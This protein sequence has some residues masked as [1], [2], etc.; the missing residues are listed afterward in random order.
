MLEEFEFLVEAVDGETH[1]VVEAAVYPFNGYATN[2][3][4]DAVG[5]GFVK[6]KVV[7]YIVV[8]VFLR[9]FCKFNFGC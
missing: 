2:P 9:K 7:F 1:D 4:L 6:R 5:T 8:Y 3:L